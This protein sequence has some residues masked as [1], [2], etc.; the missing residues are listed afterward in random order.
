MRSTSI[1]NTKCN[2]NL[3]MQLKADQRISVQ[4]NFLISSVSH[5]TGSGI[6]NVGVL[7]LYPWHLLSSLFLGNFIPI[8]G[9]SLLLKLH[10]LLT[11]TPFSTQISKIQTRIST[12]QLHTVNWLVPLTL[13]NQH[14]SSSPH[15]L[16]PLFVCIFLKKHCK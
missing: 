13:Q 5:Y 6:L 10:S 14:A 4:I 16:F 1:P 9:F 12:C 2:H 7:E 11:K 3:S 8:K 15:N